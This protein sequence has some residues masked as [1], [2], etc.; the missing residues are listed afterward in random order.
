MNE[1]NDQSCELEKVD[2]VLKELNFQKRVFSIV[3]RVH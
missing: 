2:D 1:F 3:E